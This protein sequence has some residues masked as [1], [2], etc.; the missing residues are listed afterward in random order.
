MQLKFKHG[1]EDSVLSKVQTMVLLG[2]RHTFIE[3][4]KPYQQTKDQLCVQDGCDLLGSRVVVPIAAQAKVT[5]ENHQG[6]PGITTMKGL[7]RSFVWCP[8]MEI[9]S[10]EMV[11]SC[12]NCQQN[13][14]APPVTPLHPREWPK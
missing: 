13:Q 14:N 5:K 2:W 10:E 8:G 4:L 12:T 11:R 6:H 7:A 1:P 3:Q 9:V